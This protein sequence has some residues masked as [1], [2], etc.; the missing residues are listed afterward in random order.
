MKNILVLLIMVFYALLVS[1]EINKGL[2]MGVHINAGLSKMDAYDNDGFALG[3]GAGWIIEYN[4]KSM[5]FIQSGIGIENMA[6]K[7]IN[8]TKNVFYAQ[9][10][11][12][13]GYRIYIMVK[14]AVSYKPGQ[15]SV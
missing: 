6:Y 4:V 9:I 14:I 3:Y 15:F 1:A 5:I 10:P 13:A 8:D 2:N 12:N 7:D 11:L